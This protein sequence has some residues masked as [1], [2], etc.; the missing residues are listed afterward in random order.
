MRLQLNGSQATVALALATW[1][2]LGSPASAGA[3]AAPQIAIGGTAAERLEAARA[4]VPLLKD[5]KR[6]AQPGVKVEPGAAPNS[7]FTGRPSTL[8][9]FT[10]SK[11][12]VP[13]DSRVLEAMDQ[14]LA[15]NVN[16]PARQDVAQLFDQWLAELSARSS[17]ALR[18]T[19]GGTCDAACV[20]QRMTRL[21][22]SWSSSP[23]DRADARDELL[24]DA[25]A[26]VV[27]K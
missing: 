19:G 21:D 27:T 11:R 4:L 22:E 6:R 13:V 24:L 2:A 25:L 9:A 1:F 16:D 8:F 18:L 23:R 17:A 20:V 7:P 12:S 10:V 15:W 26:T 5:V 14:L 3:Q